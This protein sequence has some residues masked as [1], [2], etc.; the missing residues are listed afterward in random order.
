MSELSIL[1]I[2]IGGAFGSVSR[3]F[4]CQRNGTPAL[5]FST[6][7]HFGGECSGLTGPWLTGN[8]FS[9][10]SGNQHCSAARNC[11]RFFRGLHHFFRFQLRICSTITQRCRLESTSQ[12]RSQYCSLPWNVLPRYTISPHKLILP[13]FSV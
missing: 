8:G 1:A 3:F 9:E 11:C 10:S 2:A 13:L 6:L 7:R 12:C 5:K 4:C